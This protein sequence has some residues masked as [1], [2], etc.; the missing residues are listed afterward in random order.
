M[1][2]EG[3]S[4][5]GSLS[6]G[7]CEPAAASLATPLNYLT[8]KSWAV[9]L[10]V[11]SLAAAVLALATTARK[12]LG[13][14]V[15]ALPPLAVPPLAPLASAAA[16]L[17][18]AAWDLAAHQHPVPLAAAE[19][20]VLLPLR[21]VPY[22]ATLRFL[23]SP[24]PRETGILPLRQI[25][26]LRCPPEAE[27]TA[28]MTLP[29][30]GGKGPQGSLTSLLLAAAA[31]PPLAVTLLVA[32]QTWAVALMTMRPARQRL[33]R[34]VSTSVTHSSRGR[35]HSLGSSRPARRCQRRRPPP[36]Q[37]CWERLTR[38]TTMRSTHPAVDLSLVH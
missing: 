4:S 6:G 8:L 12:R 20:A 26:P 30:A 38:S 35:E 9:A 29:W 5:L 28:L 10:L 24:P 25:L 7:V 34:R 3:L 15:L 21:L 36:P 19:L 14:F 1:P 16:A 11:A 18:A 33:R 2:A 31:L 37:K 23:P 27:A 22:Q 13:L 17:A 32:W